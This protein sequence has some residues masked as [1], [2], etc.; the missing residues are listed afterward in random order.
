MV[1]FEKQKSIKKTEGIL[2]SKKHKRSVQ[3]SI[4]AAKN[5]VEHPMSRELMDYIIFD[6]ESHC[7][8]DRENRE[9]EFSILD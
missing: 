7:G 5:A 2:S 8:S 6:N 1:M 3:G 4:K 9:R